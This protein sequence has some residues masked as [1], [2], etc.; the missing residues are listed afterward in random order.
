[1]IIA[2]CEGEVLDGYPLIIREVCD[3]QGFLEYGNK[4][5]FL[6]NSCII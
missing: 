3:G 5:K 1:M 4:C 6:K 2:P